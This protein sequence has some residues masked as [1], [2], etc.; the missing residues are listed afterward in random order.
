[1]SNCLSKVSEAGIRNY[2][3]ATNASLHRQSLGELAT[4]FPVTGSFTEYAERFADDALAF[5]LGWGYWYLWITVL[6]NEY[7]AISLVVMYWTDVV[8]Q[9][10]WILIFWALF[11]SLSMLGVLAYGEV[12]F[13]LSLIKVVSITIFFIVAIAISAG[14]IG[15]ENIGFK[16]WKDPGAFADGTNGVARTFVIAGTLYAG[17]EMV[18]VAAGEAENPTKAVPRAIR[19]VFWRILIVSDVFHGLVF[20][21]GFN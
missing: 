1:M 18:G 15:G 9:W 4:L 2:I 20:V 10:A 16:Y 17:T 7:N 8:P 21:H 12:E 11:L 13:W 3:A 14:G 19:Q 5:A 6:A